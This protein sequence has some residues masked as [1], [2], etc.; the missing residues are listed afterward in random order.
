MRPFWVAVIAIACLALVTLPAIVSAYNCVDTIRADP[1]WGTGPGGHFY[2]AHL[3]CTGR[4][5]LF[6]T[7]PDPSKY[8]V[9]RTAEVGAIMVL[10]PDSN[11]PADAG[12]AG[13]CGQDKYYGH[14]GIVVGVGGGSIQVYEQGWGYPGAP[15]TFTHAYPCAVMWF[16]HRDDTVKP[17]TTASLSGTVGNNGWYTSG[18]SVTLSA[19]DDRSGVAGT[20]YSIDGGG[21]AGY[22]GRFTVS[23]QGSHTVSYYSRDNAGNQESP[24]S[25]SFKIDS[26]PPSTSASGFSG[27]PGE[28]GWYRSGGQL[29]LTSSDATSGV[30]RTIYKLDGG[31]EQTYSGG[32]AISGDGTHTV[33]HWAIDNAGNTGTP[34][35]S[36]A[37]IDGTPPSG[38]IFLN[39]GSDATPGAAVMITAP[40]LDNAS[41]TAL[42]RFSNDGASWSDWKAYWPSSRWTI[43]VVNGVAATVYAQFKDTAGNISDTLTDS[44]TPIINVQPSA[45]ANYRMLKSTTAA[46]GLPSSSASYRLKAAAGQPSEVG[47]VSSA[48]FRISAG[49]LAGLA[50]PPG[51]SDGDGFSDAVEA[52]VGTDPLD[53]CPDVT[54][55]PGLCPGPSCD[56]HDA[57]PFDNNVDT[58]SNVLD[59][60]QYKGH[61]QI[62]VPDPNYVERLDINADECVNVLDVLLYKG[63]LQVQ[64][65]NP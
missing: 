5:G 64:C 37:P 63:H 65:T 48:G 60:L 13:T 38:H 56:G 7:C 6:Y 15:G 30:Y 42:Q 8:P 12:R 28:N 20:W 41:G 17:V 58:W 61:L 10:A 59:I 55:T 32:V 29:T 9:N 26:V 36:P 40:I 43:P 35:T 39:H 3:N 21:Y 51:D 53:A 14:V 11:N 23:A 52:Y 4:A 44:I 62:C 31:A 27:T 24:K 47:I 19:T 22:G 16:I 18:V 1:Y 34:I 33:Q 2:D 50:S 57:W 25:T 54:G 45:S 46:G 49:F